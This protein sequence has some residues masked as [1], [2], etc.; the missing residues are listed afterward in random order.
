[1]YG[2]LAGTQTWTG[3]NT[4]TQALYIPAGTL[5]GHAV[6]LGQMQSYVTGMGYTTLSAVQSWVNSQN[7]ATAASIGNGTIIV[8]GVGN[9]TGVVTFQLNQSGNA[10]GSFD[11]TPATKNDI[12]KGVDAY[13]Y[14]DHAQAGYQN[15]TQVNSA[16]NVAIQPFIQSI[17]R[18]FRPSSAPFNL[19]IT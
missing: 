4:Y 15:S 11:L 1:N 2:T 12:Q 9:L 3:Q 5:A 8:Q 14:G 13:G 18:V 10:I 19:S 7:F 6:N 16:I 17:N